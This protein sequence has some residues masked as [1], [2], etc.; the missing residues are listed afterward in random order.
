MP[1]IYSRPPD[2]IYDH[3]YAV[4]QQERI[5]RRSVGLLPIGFSTWVYR[6]A[7]IAAEATDGVL[8]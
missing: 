5:R 6:M 8:P 4:W 3:L 7:L 1:T 2:A